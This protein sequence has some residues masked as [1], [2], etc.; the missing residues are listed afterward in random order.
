MVLYSLS[1]EG[2][3]EALKLGKGVLGTYVD[4]VPHLIKGDLSKWAAN[5]DVQSIQI[6]GY[7]LHR[8]G[9]NLSMGEAPSANNNK[10]FYFMHGGAYVSLSAHPSSAVATI[11]KQLLKRCP[12]VTRAFS[13]EYR[14]CKPDIASTSTIENP[15]P[16]P[17]ALLDALA[18]YNYLVN[19]VG[20]NPADVIF[21]GD[22]AGGNL[23]LALTRYL[24]ENA[25]DE[26]LPPPPGSLIL[27]SP[28]S[29]LSDSHVLKGSSVDTNA[30]TDFISL[31]PKTATHSTASRLFVSTTQLQASPDFYLT[32]PYI[33]PA[34]LQLGAPGAVNFKGWPKTFV[35]GGGAEIL[36]DQIRVLL[37]RMRKDMG[38]DCVEYL[39]APDA[40]H[41]YLSHEIC[42]PERTQ[43]VEAIGKW[44]SKLPVTPVEVKVKASFKL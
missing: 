27:L 44:V 26:N 15:G 3:Y 18:G 7:W 8:H 29:D 1:D 33:S 21:V 43:L 37:E 36:I 39:E 17:A 24:V 40:V 23:A 9:T 10:V 20:F 6:P 19:K 12:S 22:S 25:N 4:P 38:D 2:T 41:D 11:P 32:N 16:F 28:W 35:N 13:I 5:A 34:S 42:E 31:D 14:L 30:S